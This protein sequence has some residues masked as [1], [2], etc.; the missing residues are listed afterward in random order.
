MTPYGT[1]TCGRGAS[2]PASRNFLWP[3]VARSGLL[4]FRICRVP[5]SMAPGRSGRSDLGPQHEPRDRRP[6]ASRRTLGARHI[7]LAPGVERVVH[8]ALQLDL[9]VVLVPMDHCEAVGDGLQAGSLRGLVDV[10]GDVCSMH[11]QRQP[12][13]SRVLQPVFEDDRFEAAAAV[14]VAQFDPSDVVG[15]SPF[16]LG[17]GHHLGGGHVYEVGFRVDESLDQPGACDPVDAGVLSGH[18][19][20]CK[21]P[22]RR[23]V[24]RPRISR[25]WRYFLR[26]SRWR[27]TS[28]SYS[29]RWPWSPTG[30]ATGSDGEAISR[31]PLGPSPYWFS[32]PPTS[33]KPAS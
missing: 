26:S 7:V 24:V 30:L 3:R 33:R 19:L 11:D 5:L 2:S 18:P 9:A 16:P 17:N 10:G 28:L 27:S 29:L 32:S 22:C 23:N 4:A 13:Q 12:V 20:H 14:H 1:A 25:Q 6:A 31:S 8:R 21:S 15:Q